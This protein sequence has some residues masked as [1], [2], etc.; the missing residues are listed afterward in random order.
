MSAIPGYDGP[1]NPFSTPIEALT[2]ISTTSYN[3]RAIGIRNCERMFHLASTIVGG[4][5][6]I[7]EFVAANIWPI[8]HGWAPRE[9]VSFNVNWATQEVPFPLFRLHLTDG[10]SVEDFVTE[11]EKKVNNIIVKYTMNEYK[12]YKN[13]VKHKKNINRVFSEICGEK[14]FP[15]RRPS[16]PVKMPYIVVASC[17]AAPLKAL[18]KKSSKKSQGTPNETT[19]SGVQPAKTKSLESTKRKRQTSKQISDVEL[20][21]ASSLAQMSRKKANKAVKK[22]VASE[23]RRVPSAFDDDLFTEPSQKGVFSWP[24]LRFNLHEHCPSGSENEFVDIGSFSDVAS[25][26]QKEV[27]TV[28][29]TAT[30][31]AEV[32]GAQPSTEASP[33]IAK[34]LELTIHRGD[35]PLHNIPLIE[36]RADVPEGQDPSPSIAAFN[37]SFGTS[38][39]GELLSVG[40]EVAGVGGGTSEILTLWKSPILINETGEGALEQTLHLF[41][42]TAQDSG[43][44]HYTP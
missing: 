29:A 22:I 40:Y 9:I 28:A 37:K 19:S 10:Q 1:A 23:V 18:R 20:Q 36:T 17:S 5:D 32:V 39:C 44:G 8:S 25:E 26:V 35:N 33:E 43:K 14:S 11:V 42:E 3:H 6:L 2:A 41:G 31:V 7:E 15:S 24:F 38:Y 16:P 4:R 21:A 12:S 27:V 13:L 30:V 34:N